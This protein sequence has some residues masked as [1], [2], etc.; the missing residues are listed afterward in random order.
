[1][2]D[3]ELQ[4]LEEMAAKHGGRVTCPRSGSEI[5]F[6]DLRKVFVS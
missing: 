2:A 3:P 6:T 4:A 1:M 5:A